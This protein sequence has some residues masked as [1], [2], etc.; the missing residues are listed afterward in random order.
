MVNTMIIIA[1]SITLLSIVVSMV[2]F[3]LGPTS[4]DRIVAFD[5]MS[6]SSVA[7]IAFIAALSNRII[8]MDVALV[9]GI[10][11]FLG[12]IIVARYLEKGL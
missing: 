2:R 1:V 9:Y 7:L 10:L 6:V 5:V 3:I 8:Y 12:V 4:A 11:G